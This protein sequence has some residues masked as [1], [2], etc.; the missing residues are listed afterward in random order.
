MM[1]M[2]ILNSLLIFLHKRF[3]HELYKSYFWHW[4]LY[5]NTIY[6]F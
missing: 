2:T 6:Y 3:F 1:M 4:I 5:L